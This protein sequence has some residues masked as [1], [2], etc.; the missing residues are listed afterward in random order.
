MR[1]GVA[2][3]AKSHEV[4]VL[5]RA[6]VSNLKAMMDAERVL[7]GAARPADAAAVPV[8]P[9]D[10]VAQRLAWAILTRR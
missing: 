1:Q 5:I 7:G 8:P 4:R 2:V 3:R 9:L 10:L 6:A